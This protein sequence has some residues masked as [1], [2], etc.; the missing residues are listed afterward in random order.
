M[1]G[2]GVL[3]VNESG[4]CTILTVKSKLSEMIAGMLQH[5]IMEYVGSIF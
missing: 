4:M 1:V 5:Y 2:V 3:D